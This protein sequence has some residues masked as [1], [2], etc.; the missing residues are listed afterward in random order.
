MSSPQPSSSLSFAP[1]NQKLLQAGVHLQANALKSMMLFQ[2]ESLSF[3]KRR[4]E[5][6]A[7]LWEALADSDEF[8]DAF[9][10][11]SNFIQNAA[12]DYTAEVAKVASIG[13]KIAS[14]TAQRARREVR[15]ARE[16]TATA[17]AA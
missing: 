15:G 3:L 1:A 6:D 17:T 9:D 16:D 10:I 13:S 4:F 2:V 5:A 8:N 14:E 11:M 7:K 12:N